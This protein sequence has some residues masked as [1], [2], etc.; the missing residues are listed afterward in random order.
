MDIRNT[1]VFFVLTGTLSIIII[2]NLNTSSALAVSAGTGMGA[3]ISNKQTSDGVQKVLQGVNLIMQGKTS[4]GLEQI[5]KGEQVIRASLTSQSPSN[6]IS[7]ASSIVPG[8]SGGSTDNGCATT[9]QKGQPGQLGSPALGPNGGSGGG[10]GNG[11]N[12]GINLCL[13]ANG[14]NGGNGGPGGNGGNGGSANG[15]IGGNGG[16]GGNGGKGGNGGIVGP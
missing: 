2:G 11:G 10:G 4:A 1:I 6:K 12:G 15:G 14:G 13:D 8:T 16:R 9:G 5:S 7:E 3:T